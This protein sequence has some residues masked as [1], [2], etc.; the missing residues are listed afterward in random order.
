[1]MHVMGLMHAAQVTARRGEAVANPPMHKHVMHEKI[2]DAVAGHAQ[3]H[4]KQD[5]LALQPVIEQRRGDRGE[6]K[7][8]NIVE[9]EPAPARAMM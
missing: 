7:S 8:E 5:R 4:T 6:Q 2:G 1:M 9:L 3:P